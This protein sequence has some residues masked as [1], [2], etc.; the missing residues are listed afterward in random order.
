M[1]GPVDSDL[2]ARA[3]AAKKLTQMPGG[4]VLGTNIGAFPPWFGE[5]KQFGLW[6]RNS[7][8]TGKKSLGRFPNGNFDTGP[9]SD[10]ADGTSWMTLAEA[11]AFEP[12]QVLA[13][14]KVVGVTFFG[15]TFTDHDG[16][17]WYDCVLDLDGVRDP[18]TEELTPLATTVSGECL[19]I[20]AWCEVSP[21]RTGLKI[22]GKLPAVGVSRK[23]DF[24]LEDGSG[25]EVFI[26][27]KGHL[28]L[29]GVPCDPG[30]TVGDS[31]PDLS[32][33]VEMLQGAAVVKALPK[34][35]ARP[36]LVVPQGAGGGDPE[37]LTVNRKNPCPVCGKFTRCRLTPNREVVSCY[38]KNNHNGKAA[39]KETDSAA[40]TCYLHRLKDSPEWEARTKKGRA[41]KHTAVPDEVSN[42]LTQEEPVEPPNMELRHQVYSRLLELCPVSFDHITENTPRGIDAKKLGYGTLPGKPAQKKAV[43]QLIGQFTSKDLL[44]VPGF[45]EKS[46][47]EIT[48]NSGSGLIVPCRNRLG[49]IVRI[50]R[51]DPDP[52]QKDNKW[53]PLSG[54]K[55]HDGTDAAS[56]GVT[57]H[58][59]RL[60]GP[61]GVIIT[62]GERKADSIA[63]CM[64]LIMDM[65]MGVVSVPGVAGWRSAGLIEDLKL[66]EVQRASIA[67]DS[68]VLSNAAVGRA[69]LQLATALEAAHIAAEF[70]TWDPA[71]KGMDDA[72]AGGVDAD[73]LDGDEALAYRA[74]IA[75]K[76]DLQLDGQKLQD[77]R[78]V[79]LV[80]DPQDQVLRQALSLIEKDE[81][82]FLKGGSLVAPEAVE[83]KNPDNLTAAGPMRLAP[84]STALIAAR[85][86]ELAQWRNKRDQTV[87]VP[88]W[89]AE[90]VVVCAGAMGFAGPRSI[91][92]V[93]NGPTIDEK[94]NL[95]N[96]AGYHLIG[97]A[98]WFMVA[99]V[100]GLTIP[101][102]CTLAVCQDAVARIHQVVEFFPWATNLDFPKWLTGL[103]AANARG[104]VDVSPMMLVTAHSAGS[105]K[106]YL[107]RMISWILTGAEPDLMPWPADDRNRDDELRKLLSG[108]VQGG[109]TLAAVDNFPTGSELSSAVLCAFLTAPIFKAR[110]LGVNDGTTSGGINRVFMIGSGNNVTP[111][112]DLADRMLMVRLDA[113]EENRRSNLISMYGTIGDAIGYV[114][115]LENRRGLLTEVLTIRRGFVQAGH[116]VQPGDGWGSYVEFV[117]TCVDP[118][119]WVTGLDPLSDRLQVLDEDSTGEALPVVIA[120]W[121]K[122]YRDRQVAPGQVSKDIIIPGGKYYSSPGGELLRDALLSMGKCDTAR[123]L[124]RVLRQIVGQRRKVG[125]ILW[126]FTKRAGSTGAR[127]EY[128]LVHDPKDDPND[129]DVVK[130]ELDD[131]ADDEGSSELD[132]PTQS[133]ELAI[134][135]QSNEL[136]IPTQS[137]EVA[138]LT[139]SDELDIYFSQS[140]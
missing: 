126:W 40:G 80:D 8:G 53:R 136:T 71:F 100:E 98:G 25:V 30:A 115:D 121:R 27:R 18:E 2:V 101:D 6:G 86:A 84:V 56:A 92:G 57:L 16:V 4:E 28:C 54:G 82:L 59:A 97:G 99:P 109:A 94:G 52:A 50:V 108:L 55:N 129:S 69:A 137:T 22:F 135:A 13:G 12:E 123:G 78:P 131:P 39:F 111:A 130:P 140:A 38:H 93:L 95:L 60:P 58:W 42:L 9:N 105:G 127:V 128:A 120:G 90:R 107:V 43:L 114:K 51:R 46:P 14:L 31:L 139:Q 88:K 64:S 47:G 68:D 37:W 67:Y 96:S 77:S 48:I 3:K 116:P 61:D 49:E 83:A 138:I 113:P 45:V 20:G 118:I 125:G 5:R 19:A 34:A 87:G 134:L 85:L 24:K 32:Q 122:V 104:Q 110:R 70:V 33:V 63:A 66:M 21:S 62:E 17:V 75:A 106:S 76:H 73:I 1:S 36:V 35:V 65:D 117:R 72:L 74:E 10:N 29:T 89:L 23:L 91:V 41:A 112:C 133:T 44:T 26:G 119:R 11:A 15:T 124:S 103:I 81:L 79:I 132:I 102:Q 7:A